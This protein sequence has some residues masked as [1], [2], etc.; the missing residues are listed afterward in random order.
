MRLYFVF[1]FW[2]LISNFTQALP[3]VHRISDKIVIF[4]GVI[5]SEANLVYPA[6]R[7]ILIEGNKITKVTETKE[8]LSGDCLSSCRWVD[9][10]GGFII[11]GFHD[12]HAH[13]L[14]GGAS[15]Y[16]V[17]VSGSN[18]ES[19]VSQVKFF[20]SKHSEMVWIKG[21]G[22][23]AAGYS[24]HFP[25][26]KDLDRAEKSRPVYLIDSD[27]HQV[28]ANSKAIELAKVTKETLD[29]EGGTILRESDGSPAGVFLEA[30]ADLIYNSVPPTTVEEKNLYAQNGQEIG[31]SS[32]FTSWQG[33]PEGLTTFQALRKMENEGT[34]T[35]RSFLWGDID[36]ND[37]DFQKYL[38]F[39]KNNSPDSMVQLVAFKGFIDGV[40]SSYTAALHEPYFDRL[41]TKGQ[42]IYS[43][44]KLNQLVL[45]AN[46]SGFPVAMHAI[47]DL[48]VTMALDAYE[49]SK[50]TLKHQL[51]NRIEHIE[52]LSPSDAK[53]FEELNVIA[54]MQ[55]AHMHFGSPSSSY[56]PPR[57]GPERMA[58][59]FAW[60]ELKIAGAF[61]VFGTDFPVVSWDPIEGIHCAVRRLFYDGTPFFP[62][63]RVDGETAL[64][65]FTSNP[66]KIIGWGDKIG[67]I[68]EGYL[69]DI[70]VL[71]TDPRDGMS[72]SIG[73]NSPRFVMVN[74][75][76]VFG[77]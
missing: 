9:A 11:P 21:R 55:P 76:I 50:K 22:W 37:E 24:S 7:A 63:Q 12:A 28:W 19:I 35:I 67:K 26:R 49:F 62:E 13:M 64:A 6:G 65:G 4:N 74:G 15:K 40:I 34:L 14:S 16:R 38:D 30:A 59:T 61:L 51:Y 52:T 71:P 57:L 1:I 23:N 66:A 68:R 56:Y 8:L 54:S 44:E 60:N 45:R 48:G 47:G 69:A 53:R 31:N 46:R 70:I 33:G 25:S 41:Q 18:T 2:M 58:H 73:M 42:P 20:A 27:G 3:P 72:S 43:Q 17:Q 77:N 39:Q 32:G 75:Q 10:K 36:A 29:P 5:W